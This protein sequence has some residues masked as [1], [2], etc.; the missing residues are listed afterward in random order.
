AGAAIG[1]SI[2]AI[3]GADDSE[4]R[5]TNDIFKL[6]NDVVPD[7]VRTLPY[8]YLSCGTED[9]LFKNNQ[10]FVA[11]LNHKKVPHE[12][13]EHPGIHDWVFWDDQ[14]REFLDVADRRLKK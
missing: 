7:K 11:I 12:Y 8:I 1:K 14:V 2:D 10:D 3:F 6:A 5:K 4:A 13:R 9:F